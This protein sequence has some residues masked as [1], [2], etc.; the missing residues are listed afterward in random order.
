MKRI[1]LVLI[2][3]ISSINA[4]VIDSIL[5]PM[6][7][8][9]KIGQMIIVYHSPLSFVKKYNIGGTLIMRNMI[10]NESK[11][12]TELTTTQKKMDIPLLVT[13]DQEGGKVNRLSKKAKWKNAPSAEEMSPWSFSRSYNYHTEVAEKLRELGINLNLAP[14]LDPQ[15]RSDST[16][17]Y[18]KN[19]KRA[20]S[21]GGDS[22]LV[23]FISAFTDKKIGTTA[24]HFPGYDATV[25]S[26]H[27]IAISEADSLQIDHYLK[28]FKKHRDSYQAIMMS[29]IH[30]SNISEEPAVFSHK[31]VSLAR[32]VDSSAV[33]MT[34][35]LWG[36]AL[37]S[38]VYSGPN[39]GNR[40]YPDSSFSKIV[41]L[42][43]L[44]GNDILMITYPQ[45]VPIII[46]AIKEEL[47]QD[48]TLYAQIDASVS[49]VLHLKQKLGLL[50]SES[51]QELT[52]LPADSVK[53]P[54]HSPADTTV[55][56]ELI[57]ADTVQKLGVLPKN[58]VE[59][60]ELI[61]AESAEDSVTVVEEQEPIP[62]VQERKPLLTAMEP[63]TSLFDYQ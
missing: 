8:E 10:S 35:D 49:R 40:D 46:K 59:E 18:M 31:M 32:K 39:M 27:H 19:E 54:K 51:V 56:L 29:S 24:K 5:S 3:L 9:E 44:A 13:I 15:Y 6:T 50:P 2:V 58:T 45:K 22:A 53:A 57:S 34:D 16:M 42:A 48:S 28:P 26:D 37:R 43:F 63:D 4:S 33:V 62:A 7:L 25:N 61:P 12:T 20:Y 30:Y 21:E 1:L 17:T 47:A 38:Y 60:L 52:L 41:K 23:G 55:K 11:F 14:V 36:A